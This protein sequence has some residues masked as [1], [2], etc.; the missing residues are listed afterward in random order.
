MEPFVLRGY[1]NDW[2]A[3]KWTLE[4]LNEVV[5]PS[6]NTEHLEIRFGA[7]KH[8]RG[9]V[10]VFATLIYP[11]LSASVMCGVVMIDRSE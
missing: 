3:M 1:I 4:S 5:R 7:K 6:S 11:R 8:V 2:P 10:G 9:K